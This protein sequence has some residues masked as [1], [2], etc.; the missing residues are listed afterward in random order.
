MIAIMASCEKS[1]EKEMVPDEFPQ[2]EDIVLTRAEQ[3][4][5][6]SGSDFAF[7][8]LKETFD[9]K[10]NVFLSPF[11]VQAA[12]MMAANGAD[13][14]TYDQIT[15]TIGY[16][17]YSIDDVNSMYRKI[18]EGLRTVDTSTNLE[19]ANSFWFTWDLDVKAGFKATLKDDYD[20]GSE[21]VDFGSMDDINRIN[22]WCDDK[23]HGMIPSI[24]DEP[25]SNIRFMILNALYFK[26]QW[27]QKFDAESTRKGIFQTTTGMK[28]SIDFMNQT[29]LFNYYSDENLQLCELPFGNEAFCLDILLPKDGKDF[30]A[31]V[32]E[33]NINRF[34][35]YLTYAM[36]ANVTLSV[37]KIRIA[38]KRSLV[39]T[40]KNMGLTLPF[41]AYADFRNISDE[42]L[43]INEVLHKTSFDM[44]E[45]GAKAAAV[46]AIT[47]MVA[48]GPGMKLEYPDVTFKADRPFV[49][50][51]REAT[52][53]AILF[54]GTFTG[55]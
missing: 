41:S 11:S 23:T 9:P 46:T 32:K 53:K 22:K 7:Q 52:S 12:F 38:Q 28:T 33:L 45:E 10:G 19:M 24:L 50:V 54:I 15:E 30:S 37:P 25:N 47:A 44:T 2:R 51:I 29:K 17:E 3:E 43:F 18:V 6:N 36:L 14:Q 55:M 4:I 20:A 16:K 49:F 8:L 1:D 48:A 13:G 5:L 42:S 40:L 39:E 27:R 34:N 26:G 21:C 31:F 35:E